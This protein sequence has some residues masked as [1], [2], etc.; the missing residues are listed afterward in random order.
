MLQ[1]LSDEEPR[2]FGDAGAIMTN[3]PSLTETLSMLRNYGSK[4]KYHNE[5]EGV[6]SRLDEL[7]AALLSVKL[8]HLM[9]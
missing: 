1:L 5:I 8:R 7:Q 9:N 6:N 4:I 3:D 2:A